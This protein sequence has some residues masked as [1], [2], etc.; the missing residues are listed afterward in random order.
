MWACDGLGQG[1]AGC[2]Q[3]PL[4]RE[5]PGPIFEVGAEQVP[6]RLLLEPT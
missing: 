5:L 2:F 1:G 4:P 6:L 3:E